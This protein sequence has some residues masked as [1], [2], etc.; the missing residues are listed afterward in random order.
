MFPLVDNMFLHSNEP[1]QLTLVRLLYLRSFF[2]GRPS[3]LH[4]HTQCAYASGA[5]FWFE[6]IAG[7]AAPLHRLIF[8]SIFAQYYAR[9]YFNKNLNLNS[10]MNSN[11]TSSC[12]PLGTYPRLCPLSNHLLPPLSLSHSRLEKREREGRETV[13][14]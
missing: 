7:E 5:P 1:L 9:F 10:Y 12:I 2:G 14:E 3:T 6:L 11:F 13:G 8:F 4:R